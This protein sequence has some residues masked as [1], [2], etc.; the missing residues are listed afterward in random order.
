MS[1]SIVLSAWKPEAY[2]LERSQT[3]MIDVIGLPVSSLAGFYEIGSL[4]RA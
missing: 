2:V 4:P 3:E 1:R